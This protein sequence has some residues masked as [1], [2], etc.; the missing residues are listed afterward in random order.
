MIKE[1]DWNRRTSGATEKQRR[2]KRRRKR[3]R[4]FFTLVL[5]L[6]ALAGWLV[7]QQNG[8][9][10]ETIAVEGAPDGFAGYRIAIISDLHAKEFG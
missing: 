7:W 3:I 2:K 6:A 10:T 9:S 8:L 1:E 4:R 5:V